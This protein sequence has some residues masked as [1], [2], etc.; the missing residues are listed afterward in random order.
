MVLT[1]ALRFVEKPDKELLVLRVGD[2]VHAYFPKVAAQNTDLIVAAIS[3]QSGARFWRCH[4]VPLRADKTLGEAFPVHACLVLERAAGDVSYDK[5]AFSALAT[6]L[7]AKLTTPPP[8]VP[9]RPLAVRRPKQPRAPTPAAPAAAA[10]VTPYVADLAPHI[11]ALV[12]AANRLL[13]NVKEVQKEQADLF[14]D[15]G[16]RHDALYDILLAMVS[17]RAGVPDLRPS[18][19]SR[20]CGVLSCDAHKRQLLAHTFSLDSL[21]AVSATFDLPHI[22]LDYSSQATR[23]AIC[24]QL[25]TYTKTS[26]RCTIADCRL[27]AKGGAEFTQRCVT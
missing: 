12:A 13:T 26:L 27:A 19:E 15:L 10:T 1:N 11:E 23:A 6:E 7:R 20:G 22:A 14:A 5:A 21:L 17:A 8:P 16:R 9:V 3:R 18:A 24:D 25:T 2:V 4:L